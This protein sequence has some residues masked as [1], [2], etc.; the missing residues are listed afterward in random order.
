MYFFKSIFIPPNFEFLDP[1]IDYRMGEWAMIRINKKG[2]LESR[3]G[4]QA[5]DSNF[6]K[7]AEIILSKDFNVCLNRTLDLIVIN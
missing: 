4:I 3:L 1:F 6:E 2:F 5:D 7:R